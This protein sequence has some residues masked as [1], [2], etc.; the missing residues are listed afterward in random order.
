[1]MQDVSCIIK[2]SH[3][4][5]RSKSSSN[6]KL[7]NVDHVSP[8]HDVPYQQA[9]TVC[10]MSGSLCRLDWLEYYTNPCFGLNMF[11]VC[12]FRFVCVYY[13]NHNHN[14]V[15]FCMYSIVVCSCV[16]SLHC[17]NFSFA[18]SACTCAVSGLIPF[19][20]GT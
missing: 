14:T 8:L 6:P 3:K 5:R 15:L 16:F 12:S 18:Q 13:Y 9:R 20:K 11:F 7:V 10:F 1:M 2:R 4:V 19:A 17:L